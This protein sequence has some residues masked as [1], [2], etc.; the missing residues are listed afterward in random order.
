MQLTATRAIVNRERERLQTKVM[1]KKKVVGMQYAFSTQY[2]F[3]IYFQ[4]IY[5]LGKFHH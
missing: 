1:E 3:I 2:S 5:F 4:D